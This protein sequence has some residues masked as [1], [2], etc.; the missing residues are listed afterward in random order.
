MILAQMAE[1]Q[2]KLH[3]AQNE[4]LTELAQSLAA[5]RAMLRELL[6]SSGRG[7][8]PR[9]ATLN[10]HIPK[11]GETDDAEAFLGTFQGVPEISGEP[12]AATNGEPGTAGSRP[13]GRCGGHP[14]GQTNTGTKGE[15]GWARSRAG[16]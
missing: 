8:G 2:S 13:T 11:M 15:R 6:T 5:D 10:I 7:E 4:V 16:T 3:H 1:R 14:A 9:G 12:P